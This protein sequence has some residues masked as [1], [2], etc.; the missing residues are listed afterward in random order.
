MHLNSLRATPVSS[1][2]EKER[3]KEP[4]KAVDRKVRKLISLAGSI[5]RVKE[6]SLLATAVDP[7]R[8]ILHTGKQTNHQ[9][10]W[11]ERKKNKDSRFFLAQ[12]VIPIG[13]K[14]CDSYPWINA[15]MQFLLF[16]P[17]CREILSYIPKSLQGI[18]EFA[19]RIISDAEGKRSISTGDGLYAASC[20]LNRFP[21]LFKG[22]DQI[23]NLDEAVQRLWASASLRPERPNWQLLW[24]SSKR[25][26]DLFSKESVAAAFEWLIGL[27]QL[28]ECSSHELF[29]GECLQRHYLLKETHSYME[30]DAFIEARPD[31]GKKIGYFAYLKVGGT[32]VQCAD[33]KI[34]RLKSSRSLELPLQRGIL[35]HFRRIAMR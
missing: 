33:E 27:Q 11:E 26:E 16:L 14:K 2:P 31:E 7:S 21:E 9:V 10:E 5:P 8:Q 35:F 24:D 23:V 4:D 17:T 13:L 30:M 12:G 28:Y 15:L 3:Q 32:W 25:F 18:K 34:S 1:A 20:L 29:Q 6:G 19:D 22:E